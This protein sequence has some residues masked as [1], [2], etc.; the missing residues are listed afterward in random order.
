[1]HYIDSAIDANADDRLA[2]WLNG[3]LQT[4][5]SL[6]LRTG[7]YSVAALDVVQERLEGFLRRGGE[8][9]AVLGGDVLQVDLAALEM[10]LDLVEQHPETTRA[11]VVVEPVFQNAKTYHVRHLDGRA[12]AWVGSANLTLG[13][14]VTNLEAAITLDTEDD[15]PEVVDR[16]HA[17]T[18]AAIEQPAVAV[19]DHGLIHQLDRRVQESRFRFGRAALGPASPLVLDH[20]RALLDQ[21][22]RTASG[23]PGLH[24]VST[25]LSDLDA[26]LGG[27]LRRGTLSV[28]ASRP[29]VGRSTLALN[30]LTRAAITD[31]IP[32]CLFTFETTVDEVILRVLADHTAISHR[33][34]RT[35]TLTDV[36]WTDLAQ[37][38]VGLL[39]APL[40]V[41]A[42]PAPHLEGLCAAIAGAVAAHGVELV[43]VDPVSFVLARSFAN[44]P[45]RELA[46]TARRL[47]ALAM[48]LGIRI[49]AT[50]EL[51]RQ[52]D[53]P[54]MRP[55]LGDIAGSDVIAQAADT[56]ILLHRPDAHD[57][58]Q[59]PQEADLILAKN[60]YGE[61]GTVTVAHRLKV[62][63]FLTLPS[64]WDD[65]PR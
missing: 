29:G 57:R 13:G 38:M 7:F 23:D 55:R 36:D 10:L 20:G 3:K 52:A 44:T 60:R 19:L 32:A 25:G 40:F 22:E 47:K 9:V 50:A 64:N 35:S 59:R 42:G 48:Q 1:V 43:V 12:S 2:A 30:M 39:D 54:T 28:I 51:N 21:L 14:L 8:L 17:A 5:S 49:V 26:A 45:D 33:Y 31:G 63:R 46:E 58:N 15:D 56:V 41:N 37:S 11:Y 27:G 65:P 61:R 62:S 6:T 4:A 34:L 16:V 53:Y 24:V 18:L